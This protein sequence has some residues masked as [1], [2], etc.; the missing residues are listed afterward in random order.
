MRIGKYQKEYPNEKINAVYVPTDSGLSDGKLLAAIAGRNPPDLVITNNYQGAYAL[1]EKGA[2]EPLD[3][4][5]KQLPNYKQSDYLKSFDSL[6]K[7]DGQTYLLPQDTNV[8]M[9]YY[10]ETMFQQA[11]IKQPPKTIAQLD[12]DAAKLTKMSPSGK[13]ERAGFIP[14]IEDGTQ[15]FLWGYIFGANFYDPKTNKIELDTPQLVNTYKWMDTYAKKY[16]AT[17]LKSFTSGFGGA[18][19]PSD[20]FFTGKVAMVVNGNWFTEALK[21][22]APKIKYGVVPIPAP[23]GG[24]SDATTFSTNVWLVPKGAKDP[25]DALKFALW[26]SQGPILASDINQWRS[27]AVNQSSTAGIKFY[28]KKGQITDPIYKTVME[29]AQSPKSGSPAL[30]SVAEEM[31]NDLTS[32]E[33]EVIYNNANP[34][35]LLAQLQTKLQS[36]VGPVKK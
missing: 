24:R 30:T 9:L 1:A 22:Y 25:L 28:N 12:A 3:Q 16:G 11:G 10:N 19:T 2:L 33:D 29:L 13:L 31:G 20:E 15:P 32:I 4:Y 18:F 36:E 5:L 35:T 17:T 8:E 21:Q 34:A 27:V 7:Y 23:P 14:W 6:M 26:G